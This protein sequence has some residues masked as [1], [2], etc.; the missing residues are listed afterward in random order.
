MYFY[1]MIIL[2]IAILLIPDGRP[3]KSHFSVERDVMTKTDSLS[4]YFL[5][6]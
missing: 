5:L 4:K 1:F 3:S 6:N 2:I